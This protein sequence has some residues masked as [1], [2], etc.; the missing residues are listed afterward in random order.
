[1]I[2]ECELT[3]RKREV[4][5]LICDLRAAGYP[6]F[7]TCPKCGVA[8]SFSHD[9][10]RNIKREDG[11]QGYCKS[12]MR[13]VNAKYEIVRR[14]LDRLPSSGRCGVCNEVKSSDE[15]YVDRGRL[16][17]RCKKCHCEYTSAKERANPERRRARWRAWRAKN[18]ESVNAHLRAKY[19]PQKARDKWLAIPEP[20]RRAKRKEQ[21]VKNKDRYAQR[22]E[23]L[24]DKYVHELLKLPLG[25]APKSLIDA[26]RQYIKVKRLIKELK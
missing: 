1:M 12:C 25:S 9:Y 4:T 24:S 15:F 2:T 6:P 22:R 13:D 3:E 20:L 5:K 26:K 17:Y 19:D 8:K 23:E 14:P 7:K 11:R 21:Y 10:S 18:K 16:S